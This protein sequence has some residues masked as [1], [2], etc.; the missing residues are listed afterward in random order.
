[1]KCE[2]TH[3]LSIEEWQ[4]AVVLC[5][6]RCH[7]FRILWWCV[8]PSYAA[9][10]CSFIFLRVCL[11]WSGLLG[12][13]LFGLAKTCSSCRARR[14]GNI[15]RIYVYRIYLWGRWSSPR[16]RTIGAIALDVRLRIAASFNKLVC[17]LCSLPTCLSSRHTESNSSACIR[18]LLRYIPKWQTTSDCMK[19]LRLM[20]IIWVNA[21]QTGVVTVGGGRT[22]TKLQARRHGGF[23]SI[24]TICSVIHVWHAWPLPGNVKRSPTHPKKFPRRKY[25]G[26]PHPRFRLSPILNRKLHPQFRLSAV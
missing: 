1:M 3:W 19:M 7:L 10:R 2:E 13:V 15:L 5:G 9:C 12:L 11:V 20:M 23:I 8:R 4:G 14:E 21:T 17:A 26:V 24:L 22:K 25:M 18:Y 16:P 6:R